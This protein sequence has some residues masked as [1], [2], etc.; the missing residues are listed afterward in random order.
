MA[1]PVE[2]LTAEPEPSFSAAASWFMVMVWVPEA[3]V[4]D[5]VTE[6]SE[7]A[8]VALLLLRTD[9]FTRKLL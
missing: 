9:W 5:G 8:S 1:L 4:D 3:A 6:S 2:S 7:A